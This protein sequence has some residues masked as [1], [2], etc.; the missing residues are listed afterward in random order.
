MIVTPKKKSVLFLCTLNSARSQIAEGL[1]KSNK[2]DKYR[3]YSAGIEAT[4]V[5]PYAIA[6]MAEI[7]VDISNHKSQSI[8]DYKDRDFDFVA[9]V[10]DHAKEFC[11]VFPGKSV[12]HHGFRDPGGAS[13]REGMLNSFREIR[14]EISVWIDQEF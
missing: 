3:V 7:G 6:V 5:N 8:N 12:I 4:A 11:P 2:C 14:D 10:C 1:L 13:D 9:T